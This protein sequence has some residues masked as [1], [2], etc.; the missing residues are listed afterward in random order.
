[1]QSHISNGKHSAVAIAYICM[2]GT[3]MAKRVMLAAAL[4]FPAVLS[5]R[6][7][8]GNVRVPCD[9]E[10]FWPLA[11]HGII[12]TVTFDVVPDKMVMS[13]EGEEI[14]P[15]LKTASPRATTRFSSEIPMPYFNW[16]WTRYLDAPPRRSDRWSFTDIQRAE[17]P[18]DVVAKASV[19]VARNCNSRSHRE[20][21]VNKLIAAGVPVD[22]PSTCLNNVK[23]SQG[24]RRNKTMLMRKYAVY[25]A[26]ENQIVDDYI[27]EKLWDT[28][29]AGVIPVYYGAP[30]IMSHVP[31]GSV[32]NVH[33][34]TTDQLVA[35]IQLIL[36]DARIYYSYH[37]WRHEPLPL[38]FISKYNFTHVHSQCRACRW[39]FA[40]S[41]GL[42]FN[43][44][45]Q[46]INGQ[47]AGVRP[48]PGAA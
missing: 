22:S 39:A 20:S 9:V 25:L 48:H 18:F 32:V 12:R 31:E 35:Q 26:F 30:N 24:L 43:A 23:V 28:F 13:M 38:W 10:C 3:T 45:T 29:R 41:R 19:F 46:E 2:R 1:M 8:N 27:T 33:Q 15:I 4:V 5:V 37:R 17:A 6:V 11:S 16:P 7:N 14:Y 42:S 34:Y 21:L 44:A 47:T 40:K 36:Q